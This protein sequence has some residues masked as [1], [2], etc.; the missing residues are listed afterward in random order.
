MSV[1][2]LMGLGQQVVAQLEVWRADLQEQLERIGGADEGL[3]I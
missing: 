2:E 3:R 1:E